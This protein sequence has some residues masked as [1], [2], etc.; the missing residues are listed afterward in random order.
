MSKNNMEATLNDGTY[1]IQIK[2]MP[3]TAS[4][5]VNLPLA[6]DYQ[7]AI[8]YA[9]PK[10]MTVTQFI[11]IWKFAELSGVMTLNLT[12]TTN[13]AKGA[14]IFAYFDSDATGRDVTGG[15]ATCTS[16]VGGT[17][18]KNKW[19]VWVYDGTIFNLVSVYQIN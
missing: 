19:A 2:T 16:V 13:L 15:T 11:S 7:T 5:T 9:T 12:I 1:N 4:D 10:A 17:S 3:F 6:V 14:M 18:N 8:A